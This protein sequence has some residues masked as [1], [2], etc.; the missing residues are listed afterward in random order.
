MRQDRIAG[1]RITEGLGETLMSTI[2]LM[3]R[4]RL[5]RVFLDPPGRDR[6]VVRHIDDNR[7]AKLHPG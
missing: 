2:K 4:D 3:P 1:E 6:P 7:A 5:S